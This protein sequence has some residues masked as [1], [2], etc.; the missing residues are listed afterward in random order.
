MHVLGI[1]AGGTKTVGLL[2]DEHGTVLAEARGAGANL[3]AAGELGLEKVL[4]QLIEEALDGRVIRPAAVC[5]GIAGADRG[6]D[7]EVVAA[8]MRRISPGSRVVVVNDALVA[9]V[10]GV[11]SGPGIVVIAGTGS[12]AY[13]R[14]AAGLAAR[15]GGWGP[16]IG[17]E[18]SGYWI[19]REALTAVVRDADRRGPPTRLTADVL[20]HFRAPDAAALVRIVYGPEVTR[21]NVAL[22]GP[23]VQRARDAGDAVAAQILERAA[24]ELALAAGSVAA[25]LD[26][27]G[28][29]FPCLLAGGTFRSAPWL[30]EELGRRL[31]ELAP[32]ASVRQLTEEPALGAVRLAL[33]EMRGGAQIPRYLE[34]A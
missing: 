25:R 19:G 20:A 22:L 14:N 1:D 2:A 4:H 32:R 27:R 8:I 23:I 18:G 6:G 7:A 26:M 31:G 17:D 24:E 11:G 15:S 10:A 30:V 12:I 5:L 21:N 16:V 3:Q 13:G 34:P 33:E 28:E 29:A 9:L